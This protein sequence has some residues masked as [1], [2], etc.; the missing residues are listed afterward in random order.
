MSSVSGVV[1]WS[2]DL[3]P[4]DVI[5]CEKIDVALPGVGVGGEGEPVEPVV[6]SSEDY[7]PSVSLALIE[8]LKLSD[9][10]VISHELSSL[11]SGID[12]LVCETGKAVDG[13][14]DG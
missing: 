13:V 2:D 8:C 4:E 14:N 6:G 5:A 10:D 12:L 11:F 9:G 7:V 1:V 3:P